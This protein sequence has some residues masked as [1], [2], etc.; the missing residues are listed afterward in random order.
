[1]ATEWIYRINVI[2][3]TGNNEAANALWTIIAPNGDAEAGSFGVQ[4]SA[5]GNEPATHEGISTGAT[6][7]MRLL[8]T[9]TYAVQLAAAF[10]SVQPAD[11]NDWER[12]ILSHGLIVIQSEDI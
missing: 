2:I 11:E 8:I 3:P 9:E 4:L 6:E 7:T 10:I 5:D 12:F 1:M